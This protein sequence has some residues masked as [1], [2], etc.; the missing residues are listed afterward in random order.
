MDRRSSSAEVLLELRQRAVA[1]KQQ[2]KTHQQIAESLDIGMSTSRL[3]WKLHKQGGQGNLKLGK[4]GR[5][6]GVGRTL[7]LKQEMA[8]QNAIKDKTP[9]Q[10]KMP[11]ALWSREAIGELILRR[12]GIS[13]PIRTMGEYLK[14]WGFTPQKPKRREYSQQPAEVRKW[15]EEQYPE[16]EARA[17]AESADIYWGDE[18]GVNNQDQ[19]GRSYAPKGQ[20]PIARVFAKKVSSSMISAIT[21]KG[22]LRFMLYRNGMSAKLFVNFL[23]RLVRSTPRKVF[24]IVDNLKAH[25]SGLVLKWLKEHVE[26]I[27]V[28]YL[29]AYSPDLNPDEYF[30]NI[31]K[32]QLSNK[33]A[34]STLIEQQKRML[35]QMRSN[36]K[37]PGLIASLFQA[38]SVQYANS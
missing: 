5:R 38:P 7:S 31:F 17:K 37:R 13:L 4:R 21:N 33:P 24:L 27:S 30:N 20:T 6:V 28:F 22:Q 14:R 25:K 2:G 9:D 1:M 35:C 32:R 11:F 10:L 34:I 29:P 12:Y 3:Y 36:Q 15:L 26:E 8:I 18:T 19:T 23:Q 16:I